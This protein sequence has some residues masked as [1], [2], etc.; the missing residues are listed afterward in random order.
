MA[1]A[2]CPVNDELHPFF[3]QRPKEDTD[4]VTQ[5]AKEKSHEQESQPP[6][7]SAKIPA[8]FLQQ[9]PTKS[10]P[11][12]D[13]QHKKQRFKQRQSSPSSPLWPDS[14]Y[15]YGDQQTH[16]QGNEA[17]DTNV[18][19]IGSDY[20][21]KIPSI[22]N[23]HPRGAKAISNDVAHS[24][25]KLQRDKR[26]TEFK[27]KDQ[28]LLRQPVDLQIPLLTRSKMTQLLN[29][30]YPT[31]WQKNS[32]LSLFDYLYPV[33]TDVDGLP[34]Q[35]PRFIPW[36]D[37]YRPL[38]IDG[39]VGNPE[40]CTYLRDWLQEMKVS[41]IA[42]PLSKNPKVVDKLKVEPNKTKRKL[43]IPDD[44]QDFIVD[45]DEEMGGF[46]FLE[47]LNAPMFDF[48][49]ND[50]DF[51]PDVLHSRKPRK[52]ES[53][54]TK[55]MEG[56][57][58]SNL[59][60]L[61][62]DHGTGKTA[63]V[64][65]AASEVGYDVFE[66]N[67]GQKR[68][69]KEILAIVGEMAESHQVSFENVDRETFDPF[70]SF[71]KQMEVQAVTSTT[72]DQ[73]KAAKSDQ[74]TPDTGKRKRG[75]PRKND[76]TT[77]V[78]K[79]KPMAKAPSG[80]GDI[81]R[82]FLRMNVKSVSPPP[83]STILVVDKQEDDPSMIDIESIVDTPDIDN[84]TVYNAVSMNTPLLKEDSITTE[85]PSSQS[86]A[87]SSQSEPSSQIPIQEAASSEARSPRQSLILLEEVDILYDE[88]KT[89]WSGV[90]N[91][92]QKSKRPIIMTCNG[93]FQKKF[94]LVRYFSISNCS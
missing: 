31:G 26:E 62:G 1:M 49:D 54:N 39:L 76:S 80:S 15:Y 8:M 25:F 94:F 58:T 24:Y 61:V 38:T 47:L 71:A 27:S 33:P 56:R 7:P 78:K 16:S 37:K 18:N 29:T 79:P 17:Y 57:A 9:Q 90:I 52:Q 48:D 59:I 77:K 30:M 14:N 74:P 43:N 19:D 12:N 68:N 46:S 36:R 82:H 63:A 86:V 87:T 55:K 53:K 91:L 28:P 60:L 65:T 69:A 23:V 42:A 85:N 41:P 22:P 6:K 73:S 10:N 84:N 92:A 35:D 3:R 64:Y 13:N 20:D 34:T 66:I 50:E 2:E 75:R 4:S 11:P 67:A 93:R 88:D 89:F 70:A 32:F 44:L 21:R 83:D 81:T 5:V 72:S 51:Q 45:S 40:N